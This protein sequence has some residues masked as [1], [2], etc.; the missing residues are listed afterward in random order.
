MNSFENSN[1]QTD[2]LTEEE[3]IEQQTELLPKENEAQKPYV[4]NFDKC[5]V[6]AGL[7]A[8]AGENLTQM[9]SQI[10]MKEEDFVE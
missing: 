6:K 9:R 1:Q 5:F 2:M 3:K 8:D 10:K 4:F 7:V